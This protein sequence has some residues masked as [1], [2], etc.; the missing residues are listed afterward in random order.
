M[1]TQPGSDSI[2]GVDVGAE[3]E[4][5]QKESGGELESSISEMDLELQE[6]ELLN[7]LGYEAQSDG[8]FF[9]DRILLTL[10]FFL[11]RGSF[12]LVNA[13]RSQSSFLGPEP[14]VELGFASLRC[15]AEFRPKLRYASFDISLG[16]LMVQDHVD[17][18]SLFP[19][20]VQPKGGK[21]SFLLMVEGWW[22]EGRRMVKVC[23]EG[24]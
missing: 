11:G 6:D 19:V 20:L 22:K 23:F 7:E 12:Q 10:T 1:Q 16:S 3:A 21:V 9:R 15:A 18:E 24:W 2:P 4:N 5:S 13:S 8:L 14:L 17:S